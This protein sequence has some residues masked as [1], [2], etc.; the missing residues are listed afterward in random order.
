MN[1][2]CQ[3]FSHVNKA[4]FNE[5]DFFYDFHYYELYDKN[6]TYSKTPFKQNY[7]YGDFTYSYT[8]YTI[9]FIENKKT[10]EKLH[11][12]IVE[13]KI[14]KD[15]ISKLSRF[16]QCEVC[17]AGRCNIIAKYFTCSCCVGCLKSPFPQQYQIN[18][19]R[20]FLNDKKL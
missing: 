2:I 15:E 18:K 17:T 14:E 11:Y 10:I 12:V 13:E 5:K 8:L 4:T 20:N 6:K 7:G 3:K 9:S 19:T 1:F 16:C